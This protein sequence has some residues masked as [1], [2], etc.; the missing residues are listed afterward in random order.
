VNAPSYIFLDFDGT[1]VNSETLALDAE[2]KLI[3]SFG[4]SIDHT[5]FIKRYKDLSIEEFATELSELTGVTNN[6]KELLEVTYADAWQNGL[7]AHEGVIEFLEEYLHR[8]VITTNT[9]LLQLKMKLE[10]CRM[11]SG[12]ANRAI[13]G[14][15]VVKRKPDPQT[16]ELA[17]DLVSK[18]P[19]EVLAVEDSTSGIRS[20]N[21]AAITAFGFAGGVENSNEL[22]AAGAKAIIPDWHSA[23]NLIGIN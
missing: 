16:Y 10:I 2:I 23:A 21:R 22:L 19:D 18:S 8:I 20:A 1:L 9:S 11:P 7:C 6:W 4:V 13:T 14:D 5:A 3:E 12:L 15:H 17:L